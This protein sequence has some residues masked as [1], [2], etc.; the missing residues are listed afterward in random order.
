[1]ALL[2]V[3]D[4]VLANYIAYNSFYGIANSSRRK[5]DV[6]IAQSLYFLE[7]YLF[8]DIRK[9]AAGVLNRNSPR[10]LDTTRAATKYATVNTMFSSYSSI[11]KSLRIS[12]F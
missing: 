8:L 3:A 5:I 1:M 7:N 6:F 12:Y 11:N 10:Y 4:L 9:K 2:K